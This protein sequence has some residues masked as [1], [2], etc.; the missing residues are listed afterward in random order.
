MKPIDIVLIVLV[1]A[2]VVGAIA[3]LIRQ[4]IKGKTGCGCG[5]SNCPSAGACGAKNA[6]KNEKTVS[7]EED[8]A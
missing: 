3:Y 1:A 5:C 8:D 4:K 6:P 7:G 2:A